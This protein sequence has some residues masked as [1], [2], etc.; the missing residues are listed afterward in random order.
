VAT[1]VRPL[2]VLRTLL[3]SG[4]LALICAGVLLDTLATHGRKS[5]VI[6]RGQRPSDGL[7]DLPASA[8]GPVSA[9]IGSNA[10]AYRL[11]RSRNAFSASNPAQGFTEHFTNAGV[12]VTSSS[13]ELSLRLNGYGRGRTLDGVHSQAP[14]HASGNRA[15]YARGAGLSEW[16]ANG[17][18]GL[19]Q[20]FTLARAPSAGTG[21]RLTLSFSLAGSRGGRLQA[22]A[23]ALRLRHGG[24]TLL[25]YG[26]LEVTDASGKTLPSSLELHDSRL[27]LTVVD[28]NAR[29]P[30]KIDPLIQQGPKLV[31]SDETLGTEPGKEGPLSEIGTSVAISADGNTIIAGGVGDEANHVESMAGAAWVFVRNGAVWSQQGPKLVGLDEKGEGQFG[32]SVALSADGSTAIVGGV[33]DE[34]L[35]SENEK[36]EQFGA[37]WVFERSGTTWTQQGPK[38][39]ASPTEKVQG[40]RFGKSVA[41]S[42]D[43]S[44]AL[45]GA[46]FKQG[47]FG[48]VFTRSGSTW[49]QQGPRL[50]VAKSEEPTEGELGFSAALS[51]DGNTALLGAPD[52]ESK[53][54]FMSG[55]GWVF[56]RTGTTWAQ[57]GGALTASDEAG[58]GELGT[59]A[60][61][62][63][64]GNTALLG[65]PAEGESGA[66]WVF[67]RSGTTWAQ[68]G[69]KLTPNDSKGTGVAF[70][71]GVALSADGNTALI[72]G[73]VDTPGEKVP[74]GSAWE[75]LRSGTTWAQ[76][77]AKI[78][79]TDEGLE[80]EGEFAAAVALSAD[81]A[82]AALG[83]PIDGANAGAL[84]PFID[85]A[86]SASTDPAA[87]ITPT[88]ATLGGTVAE[89]AAHISYFQY[90]TTTS[91]GSTTAPAAS[92]P[93]SAPAPVAATLTGLAPHT[94]YH[95]RF[96]VENSAGD[97]AGADASFTTPLPAPPVISH[98][99]QSHK[100]W[101]TGGKLATIARHKSKPRKPPQGTTYSFTL[102][103]SATLH[104]TFTQ[105]VGGRKVKD[106][107][108]AR[109]RSNAHKP[110]CKRKLTR[111]TLTLSGRQGADQLRFQGRLSKSKRLKPG[112][113]TVSIVAA[114]TFGQHSNTVH[115]TFTVAA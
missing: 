109:S 15:S 42:A 20:G 111:G 69:G 4:L 82:T 13:A 12:T 70:G 87:A 72:G 56:T 40:E 80:E 17:P 26:N 55:A 108:V 21:G 84:R 48:W 58:G 25:T 53:T 61:L 49:T 14:V 38:L 27:L 35:N 32:I 54:G 37:A 18:A 52:D 59:S 99:K 57:Q 93:L 60:A 104:L 92:D 101:R 9:A 22:A 10:A 65:A 6:T 103:E 89:G 100:K 11:T 98:A 24:A 94:T 30:L 110:S 77:G 112:T 39:T 85:P 105:L 47:G 76:R 90:G 86:P 75:F 8:L 50:A 5:G 96:V 33:N 46:F 29:Y 106:K 2:P 95:F 28:E 67:T 3:L 83:A 66:A 34:S 102:S 51:A 36:Q 63:A 71:A 44:T 114:D 62:S 1:L 81:G 31:G 19:E 45:V 74:S 115:L 41:L 97:T 88:T 23:G 78:R 79:G 107:C 43:G 73:P 68:Q 64:D 113:Y 7:A 16:Y 91:Y